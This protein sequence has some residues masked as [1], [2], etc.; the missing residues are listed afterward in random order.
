MSNMSGEEREVVGKWVAAL[1]SGRY[2]QTQGVFKRHNCYCALGVLHNEINGE[3]VLDCNDGW[4]PDAGLDS[5][6]LTGI[7]M[8]HLD[9]IVS[10]NDD[11]GKTFAEIA[12][13]IEAQLA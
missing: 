6:D 4:V 9:E 2:K 3:W 7:P 11:D 10:M 12:D 1:R 13:Y 5:Y 8:E